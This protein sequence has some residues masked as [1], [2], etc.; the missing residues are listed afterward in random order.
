MAQNLPWV[1]HELVSK[2]PPESGDKS[3]VTLERHRSGNLQKGTRAEH[4]PDH[5][6]G[7][8][9]TA[10]MAELLPLRSGRKPLQGTG[11]LASA[12]TAEHSMAAVEA[13]IYPSKEPD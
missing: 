13:I 7:E 4:A 12:E 5:S 8:S 11:W 9:E 2:T 3:G 1:Q 10:G 6:R